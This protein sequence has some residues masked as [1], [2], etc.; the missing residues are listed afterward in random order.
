VNGQRVFDSDNGR[1][2]GQVQRELAALAHN[3]VVGLFAA[4]TATEAERAAALPGDEIV[5]D[6]DVVMDRG[7][8]VPAAPEV[9]WPWLVQLG[10][11]RAGWYLPRAVE[12]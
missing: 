4:V 6:P 11:A 7:F 10:K 12:R 9:V 3:E 1:S 5:A 2:P 8:G